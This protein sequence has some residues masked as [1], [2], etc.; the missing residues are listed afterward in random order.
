ME[1]IQ[2][3]YSNTALGGTSTDIG[4]Y[5]N[6]VENTPNYLVGAG[7]S[8]TQTSISSSVV[9]HPPTT[10]LLPSR[11]PGAAWEENGS[12]VVS[13]FSDGLCTS[14]YVTNGGESTGGGN[15]DQMETTLSQ[16]Y[17]PISFC[18]ETGILIDYTS[19]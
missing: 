7:N 1:G 16:R 11:L 12:Q 14:G 9:P 17:E 19:F 4:N 6:T 5:T 2:H 10:S 15:G 13:V 3:S 8:Q 18:G